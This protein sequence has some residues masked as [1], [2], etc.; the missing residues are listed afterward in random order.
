MRFASLDLREIE[1]LSVDLNVG[2]WGGPLG[3]RI[4]QCPYLLVDLR[5]Q[6]T[7]CENVCG[8]GNYQ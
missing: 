5:C 8:C 3:V 7:L 2:L 6:G 4:T 1:R